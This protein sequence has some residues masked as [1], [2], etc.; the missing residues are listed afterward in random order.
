[1]PGAA[2][3]A[4]GQGEDR[5]RRA[6]RGAVDP[7]PPPARDL[8]LPGRP[9]RPDRRAPRGSQRAADAALPRQPPRPFRT[10]GSARAPRAAG[11]DLRLQR[12]E[13]RC[14]RQHRLSR[15]APRPLLLRPL[16]A[17]PRTRRR[18]PDRDHRRDLPP[19]PWTPSRLIDWART[20]GPQTAALV[21]AI[22]ADRPH[23]EQGYRSCLGLLRLAKGYG[24]DRLEA[25]S[26]TCWP[27]RNPALRDGAR[28]STRTSSVAKGRTAS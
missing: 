25:A 22:L 19:R 26:L 28:T 18:A 17:H 14:P 27:Y 9:Q 3:E 13:D 6:S 20:I 8:L 21:E 12:V 23:P 15:R 10:A 24:P 5:S 2:G 16:R 1:P 4:P 7:R 11:G